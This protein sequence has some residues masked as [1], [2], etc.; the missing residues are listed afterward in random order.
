VSFES[1]ASGENLNYEWFFG[2]N[3]MSEEENPVHTYTMPG[4]YQVLLQVKNDCGTDTVML[5]VNLIVD[6]VE[7]VEWLEEMTVFPN[8]ND[9]RF[10][11]EMNG[12]PVD[13]LNLRLFNVLGQ[14]FYQ[15]KVDFSTGHLNKEIRLN[16]LISGL[17]LLEISA[18]N[19]SVYR[20]IIIK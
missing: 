19:S 15:E 14:Q 5:E 3:M 1:T 20:K 13:N 16:Q 12:Q 7:S 11:L 2:D 8:P 9:G 6:D 4:I 10:V 17:Y 18:E